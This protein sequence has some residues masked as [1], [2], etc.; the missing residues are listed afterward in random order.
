MKVFFFPPSL[1]SFSQ[2][3]LNKK[4]LAAWCVTH[5][6]LVIWHP[7]AE[8]QHK[9]AG[10]RRA[11]TRAHTH[12]QKKEES[13]EIAGYLLQRTLVSATGGAQ[14]LRKTEK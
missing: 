6:S 14:L 4:R 11:N 5:A 13:A 7:A 1:L 10:A 8:A 9:H 12:A 2:K 3:K